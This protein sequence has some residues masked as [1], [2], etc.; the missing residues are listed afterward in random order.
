MQRD[1]RYTN[2]VKFEDLNIP[3]WSLPGGALSPELM[4]I[5]YTR[6][7]RT[8]DDVAALLLP[9]RYEP[10][11]PTELPGTEKAIRTI[12]RLH[13]GDKV[14]VWGDFDVDGMT[15]TAMLV[16]GLRK[17]GFDAVFHIPKRREGHGVHIDALSDLVAE[18]RPVLTL[19]CDTG[20]DAHDEIEYLRDHNILTVIADHHDINPP[21][22]RADAIIN[23]QLLR[24]ST[25]PLI[26]LSGAGVSYLFLEALFL[27]YGHKREAEGFLDLVALGLIADVV[28]QVDDVRYLIQRGMRA[29]QHTKRLGIQALA[30]QLDLELT[31]LTSKDVAFSLAP[32]INAFGRLDDPALGFELL[33][34]TDPTRAQYLAG[35][36]DSLNQKRKMLTRQITESAEGMISDN[37]SLVEEWEALVLHSPGW[38]GSMLGP[39]AARLA[40]KYQKPVALLVEKDNGIASGSVRSIDGYPVN[41]ALNALDDIL[42]AYGGHEGAGGLSLYAEHLPSLRRTLSNAFANVRQPGADTALMVEGVLPLE[43]LTLDFAL[44]VQRLSP[45]GNG[46]DAPVFV[47]RDLQIRSAA[48][49]GRNDDHRRLIVENRDG[50]R[51][52]VFWWNSGDLDM[53]SQRIDLAYT[54]DVSTFKGE[55]QMQIDL[56]DFHLLAD[57][58]KQSETKLEFLDYRDWDNLSAVLNEIHN[59]D[60]RAIVWAEGFP[61]SNSPGLTYSELG[62]ADA[63][64]ILSAPADPDQFE[65]A[66]ARV[67]PHRIYLVAADPPVNTLSDFLKILYGLASKV[68]EDAGGSV[69]IQKLM[70]RLA[71]SRSVIQLGLHYLEALGK[72]RVEFGERTRIEFER[73]DGIPSGDVEGVERRLR[74]AWEE[75]ETYRRYLRRVD[76]DQLLKGL[77]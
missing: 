36:A 30:T 29:L 62:E 33:T 16:E 31:N 18:H 49:L 17:I 67:S 37:P 69:N 14:L 32:A 8:E 20:S 46:N 27:E 57:D 6:G 7:F 9:E 54:L 73:G 47:T 66:V 22:P 19:V 39:V 60:S 50:Q 76:I 42:L 28:K 61:T 11:L 48:K 41:E 51:Q 45:F 10:T 24:E 75:V 77:Q 58:V 74:A 5:V 34:T 64:I 63:L 53:P 35:V 44:E 56:V 1:W 72:I 65:K 3:D 40:D 12:R 25:H 52:H 55:R 2:A 38:D 68:I 13:A 70:E 23:P 71:Q 26:H 15:S 4:A 59:A 21:L 43:R